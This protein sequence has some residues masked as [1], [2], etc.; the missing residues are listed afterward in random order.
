MFFNVVTQM[1]K[2]L[3]VIMESISLHIKDVRSITPL[4]LPI[5]EKPCG[6]RKLK[7]KSWATLFP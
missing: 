3:K 6:F 2:A 1:I 5:F 4:T 7:D